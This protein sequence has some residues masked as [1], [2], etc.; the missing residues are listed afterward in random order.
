MKARCWKC[1]AAFKFDENRINKKALIKCPVCESRTLIQENTD[2]ASPR[3]VIKPYKGKPKSAAS[4]QPPIKQPAPPVVSNSMFE[5][6]KS[7]QNTNKQDDNWISH[8]TPT[9]GDGSSEL[10]IKHE[11]T[12]KRS[13]D[14]QGLEMSDL[15]A[16]L[17]RNNRRGLDIM[18]VD[19]REK[20]IKDQNKVEQDSDSGSTGR[21]KK[22][23]RQLKAEN[24]PSVKE[25]SRPKH[26]H[27]PKPPKEP[28]RYVNY[29]ILVLLLVIVAGGLYVFKP[30]LFGLK[31]AATPAIKEVK[32][33]PGKEKLNELMD[34]AGA[35][36]GNAMQLIKQA[37]I[38]YQKDLPEEYVKAQE[39]FKKA[40]AIDSEN[41]ELIVRYVESYAKVNTSNVKMGEIRAFM[42]MLEY[43]DML[44]PGLS[45]IHRAKSRIYFM[46]EQYEKAMKEAEI[47]KRLEENNL[48]NW[49]ALAEIAL[50]SDPRR[51]IEI[52]S[53]VVESPKVIKSAILPLAKAYAS[54]GKY[55]MAEEIIKK[56]DAMDAHSCALCGY[57]GKMYESVGQYE[58]AKDIYKILIEK[59]PENAEGYIG[60]ANVDYKSGMSLKDVR[61]VLS[62]LDPKIVN[63][64]SNDGRVSLFCHSSHY[65]LL[66]EDLDYAIVVAEKAY[67]LDNESLC[68]RYQYALTQTLSGDLSVAERQTILNIIDG[69][70]FDLPDAP[71]ITVL[72]GLF[73]N[74]IG[75]L[76]SAMDKF[77]QASQKY[78]KYF[79]GSLLL[80]LMHL[81]TVNPAKAFSVLEK[82]FN[83][84]P[85]V[86][87]MEQEDNIYTD[88]FLYEKTLTKKL[89]NVDEAAMDRDR[90]S[91]VNGLVTYLIGENKQSVNFFEDVLENNRKSTRANMFLSDLSYQNGDLNK[92]RLY[93]KAVLKKHRK[94]SAAN[95]QL[96]R[97]LAKSGN[98]KKAIEKIVKDVP[99]N[100]QY[101]S[102]QS[103][104][105][106]LYLSSE[107]PVKARK[108]AWLAYKLDNNSIQTK[109]VLYKA[110][111]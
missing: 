1:G 74:Q 28:N 110:N 13:D 51:T 75:N 62:T 70:D 82:L 79:A 19:E 83:Y 64:F 105:A 24:E 34:E 5:N 72:W 91:A 106:Q 3:F 87:K 92:A 15:N 20:E 60:L 32:I 107:E 37:E 31:E 40:L 38:L 96:A 29:I 61:D 66:A 69:L 36:T 67:K 39:L 77:Q 33:H 52:L 7:T 49:V 27:V 17:V 93:I 43:A 86:L 46:L 14:V 10:G 57:L 45:S 84:P 6:S 50:K 11:Q 22:P 89:R 21:E 73:N 9:S 65:S 90:K 80:S 63:S 102:A 58:K 55:N 95:Y 59:R 81:E 25:E 68:G 97:I 2:A 71:E 56:R 12:F 8:G 48:E 101:A 42:D 4:Q 100:K 53:D 47:A 54:V 99:V 98:T 41:A 108:A 30:E 78:P 104:L 94:D 103:L 44:A 76:K 18:P 26:P 109:T 23:S 88:V 111:Q 85:Y 16:P 35:Q